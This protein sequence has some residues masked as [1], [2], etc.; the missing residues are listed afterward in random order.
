MANE[1][2]ESVQV[3]KQDGFEQGKRVVEYSTP[4]SRVLL[5]RVI[6]L[7][8]LIT[9]VI[10]VLVAFRFMLMLIAANPA[11]GFASFIY[12]ITDV[13][14]GPFMGLTAT[15]NLMGGSVIDVASL[16]A[17]VVY[18]VLTWVIVWLLRILFTSPRQARQVTTVRR[19]RE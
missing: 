8:W 13:L 1:R 5:S 3:E 4:T 11:S 19:V 16:F 14:V 7:L 9:T 2:K 15:P 17:L 6:K 12:Q 10:I 18:P